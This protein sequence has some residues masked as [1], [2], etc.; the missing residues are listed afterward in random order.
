MEIVLVTGGAGFIGSHLVPKLV[1]AGYGVRV[2]DN[3]SPQVHGHIPV[4]YDWLN[5]PGVEF[6]RGSILNR[7]DVEAAL[8]SASYVIHLAAETGT[9]QSMYQVAHYNAVNVQG[10]AVLVD[11]L[12]SSAGA[13]VKHVTLSSSRSVYGEGAYVREDGKRVFPKSRTL[14]QLSAHEWE[15]K[16]PETGTPLTFVSTCE[17]DSTWPVSI[18]A[19]TKLAQEDLVRIGCE[20]L[21]RTYAVLRLQ[22]VYGEGQSLNNPYTGILSIFSTRIR[23]GLELPIF[24][25]GLE[26]RD[27]VHVED[28]AEAMV[29]TLTT[30]KP[31][32]TVIN[33]GSGKA[34][35]VLNVAI[36]L[37]KAM[38]VAPK[39]RVTGQF[40]VGDIRHN[41]ADI[42]RLQQYLDYTPRIHLNEGLSHFA[43]WVLSQ[44]LPEDRL[45]AANKE[46]RDRKLMG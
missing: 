4:G 10:T 24:E 22:N 14:V 8:H 40:R 34:T 16:C 36:E 20:A 46:L 1:K 11:A 12:G 38:G 23:R 25:D 6:I 9:G 29:R 41:F 45:E 18:Y 2:L 15:H 32:N 43:Q 31:I 3:L 19:A 13:S 5:A 37:S 26:T 17:D 33:V 30:S 35:T 42:E 7:E 27:F 44:P 28:V 39:V 21:G